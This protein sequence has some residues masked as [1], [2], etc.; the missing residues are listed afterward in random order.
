MAKECM[1]MTG[2]GRADFMVTCSLAPSEDIELD[3]SQLSEVQENYTVEV[4]SLNNRY[5]EVTYRSPESFNRFEIKVRELIKSRFSRGSFSISIR[6]VMGGGGSTSLNIG[7][8]R[9]YLDAEKDLKHR[10]ALQGEL[11]IDFMLRQKDIFSPQLVGGCNETVEWDALKS[12]LN[13]ALDALSKMR[14]EEGESLK[15]DVLGRV[16]VIEGLLNVIDKKVPHAV[17]EHRER[18]KVEF[19]DFI[20]SGVISDERIIA[21]ASIFAE[22]TNIA[23]EVIR[24]K[25]HVSQARKYLSLPEPVGRRLDFL[26]QEILREANTIGSKSQDIE[27]SGKVIEIK[28]ELE[29]IREQVQNIE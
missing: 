19:R 6:S 3:E 8:I 12:G 28:G 24:F 13:E 16:D 22:K 17:A 23:E 5:L 20:G 2:Y 29:K 4:K 7:L 15:E 10:F 11:G 1:S 26:C 25:S 21:E 18:L 14:A 27:V 9:N